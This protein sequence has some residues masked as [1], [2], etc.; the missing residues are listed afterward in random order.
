MSGAPPRAE[1]VPER[2]AT[3]SGT[4]AA[5]SV[6]TSGVARYLGPPTGVTAPIEYLADGEHQNT[7]KTILNRPVAE[8]NDISNTSG[9]ALDQVGTCPNQSESREP[10][11]S[12]RA[13]RTSMLAIPPT[14][15]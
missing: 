5:I 1:I 13:N 9:E 4:V 7:R 12:S 15:T 2:P 6:R 14:I 10:A 11:V 8:P 3:T